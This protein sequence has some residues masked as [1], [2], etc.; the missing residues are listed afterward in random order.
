MAII[1]NVPETL[2]ISNCSECGHL[3]RGIWA[4]IILVTLTN[5]TSDDCSLSSASAVAAWQ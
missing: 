4:D 3:T 2:R 1:Y 5:L